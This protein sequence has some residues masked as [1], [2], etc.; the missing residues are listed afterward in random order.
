MKQLLYLFICIFIAACS[1]NPQQDNS[2]TQEKDESEN[3]LD[4][5]VEET[6]ETQTEMSKAELLLGTW[7]FE[8]PK[9]KVVQV[10]TYNA[11]GTYQM[12]M[13]NMDISGTWELEDDI[14]T[15]K[16]RPDA[17]GQKKT[18]TKL[19]AENLWTYWEPA[20]G[21]KARELQYKRV[22]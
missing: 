1:P 20:G 2:E 3:T 8:D 13:A 5:E 4:T 9:L 19:D 12:K 6:V 18:I 15:T 11:D 14:L 7:Q 22:K 10:I 16:S 21:G 17:P